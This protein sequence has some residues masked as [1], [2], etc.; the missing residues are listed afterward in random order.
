MDF[1]KTPRINTATPVVA[2]GDQLR[3]ATAADFVEMTKPRLS[4][5]SVITALVGYLMA[6]P[7][8]DFVGFFCLLAGTALAAGGAAAVNQWIER[9]PD[10]KMKRTQ[11]RPLP[12][13]RVSPASAL[14]FGGIL[15]VAGP[16]LLLIG[17]NAL[18]A[19]LTALTILSYVLIYTPLKRV[20]PWATEV[21]AFPGAIP[22]LIGWA[23]GAG[24]LGVL[25]WFL[26][27][28]LFAWQM[29]HFMAISWMFREDYAKG[30]FRMLSI[31]DPSGKAA[32]RSALLWAIILF[33]VGLV[34]FMVMSPGI[35]YTLLGPL[36]CGWMLLEAIS[37]YRAAGKDRPARRLF[38]ASIA[39]LPAYLIALLV[40]YYIF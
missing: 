33:V 38:F 26:F 11:D 20:T 27:A 8:R 4:L 2:G 15:C 28:L 32:A 12:A 19:A 23:A 9:G 10:G 22:P 5:M 37:F 40:D 25:G 39:F 24:S 17:T 16:L 13:G 14:I 3:R 6:A 1:Q 31:D 21:G 7:E 34:P 30:G 18:A 29:P 36:L 35:V